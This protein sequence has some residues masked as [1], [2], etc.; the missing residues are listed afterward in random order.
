MAGLEPPTT[1]EPAA[2]R[3]WPKAMR[4]QVEIIRELLNT[5]PRNVEQLVGHFQRKPLKAVL[6][7]LETLEAMN[8][9]HREDDRWRWG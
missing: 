9:A 8:L 4:E 3:P 2:K 6:A 5:G 7:V 1:S